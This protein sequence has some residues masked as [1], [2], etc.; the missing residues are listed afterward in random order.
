[1][2]LSIYCAQQQV[3]KQFELICA[4]VLSTGFNQLVRDKHKLALI[5]MP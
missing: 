4:R 5:A 1:M 2:W 3:E